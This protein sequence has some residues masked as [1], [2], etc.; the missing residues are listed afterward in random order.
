ML[1]G[2]TIE[3]IIICPSPKEPVPLVPA[4]TSPIEKLAK[5]FATAVV[6]VAV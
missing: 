3:V 4:M 6:I 2:L 5:P 1:V